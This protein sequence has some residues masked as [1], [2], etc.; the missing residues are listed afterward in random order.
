MIEGEWCIMRLYFQQSDG[1]ER[2]L[3]EVDSKEEA[4]DA[5]SKFIEEKNYK[6]YYRIWNMHE[7]KYVIDVGSHTEFLILYK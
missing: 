4:N 7:D 5:I 1:K 3:V 2:F 6:S